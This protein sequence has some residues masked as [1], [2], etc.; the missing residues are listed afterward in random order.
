M[1]LWPFS[2]LESG[3]AP[4]TDIASGYWQSVS[5]NE[6]APWPPRFLGAEANSRGFHETFFILAFA[7][8]LSRA[9]RAQAQGL[10]PDEVVD[11]NL[12]EGRAARDGVPPSQ[13]D[14]GASR[15]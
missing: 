6:Y 7:R 13:P 3:N 5:I 11:V 4:I 2:D 12:N 8:D 9:H 1:G 14:D 10:V 15:F